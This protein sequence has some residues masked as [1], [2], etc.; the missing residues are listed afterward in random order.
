MADMKH[1]LDKKRSTPWLRWLVGLEF[2]GIILVG[3]L[4]IV[5][6]FRLN[7]LSGLSFVKPPTATIPPLSPVT[8]SVS[9]ATASPS[10]EQSSES[11]A[12]P[13]VPVVTFDPSMANQ[14]VPADILEEVSYYGGGG[15]PGDCLHL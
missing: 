14:I 2:A 15:G 4:M 3:I 8:A 11:T 7:W 5:L 9:Q 6:A 10:S 12:I 13:T 1:K